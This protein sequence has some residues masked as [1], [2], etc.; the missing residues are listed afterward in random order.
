MFRSDRTDAPLLPA[1]IQRKNAYERQCARVGHMQRI[2]VTQAKISFRSF[3][4]SW[5]G[6]AYS[7]TVLAIH[8]LNTNC[9]GP[10]FVGWR[11]YEARR[12][13]AYD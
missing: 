10:A 12:G 3:W 7:S 13:S 11:E 5:K 4:D 1:S 9:V 6:W 2:C 8:T